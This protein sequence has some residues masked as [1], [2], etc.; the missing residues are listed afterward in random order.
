MDALIQDVRY[1]LRMCLRSPGFTI[2]A[3][4]ALALGI[5]ANTAIFTVVNAV[6]IERLPFR[7]PSRLV[8]LWETNARRPGRPNTLGPA[9]VIRWIERAT[10]F[11][12]IAPFYDYQ[13]NLT[14]GGEPE[15]IIAQDVTADYFPTLGVSPIAGRI[16]A[17]DEGPTG[18]DAVAVLSFGLWQ[19]RFVGSGE[20]VGRSIQIN[21]HPITVIGVMPADARLFIRR[22]SLVG[23]PAEIWM[24]FAFTAANR[25]PRG[26][27]MS[28]IARLKPGVQ[29]SEAQAQ[30]ET[31]MTG[32][33]KEFPEFDTGWSAMVVPMHRELSGDL[34]PALLVLSGAVGFVLLIACANVAN[35]L[36]ARGAA[37]RREMAIR[38]ALG[39]ARFRVIRQLLTESLVLCVLGGAA[40]LL[41]A[42]WGLALLVAISPEGLAD[43]SAVHLSYPVLAFTALVSIVTTIVC[44]FAPA[45]EASR[46]EVQ[47]GLKDGSRH[48]GAGV[49]HRRIRQGF[50]VSEIAL[51]VV[52]L[53]GAG[54]MIKSFGTL[55]S[56]NPGFDAQ[57]VLTARL[58]IPAARYPDDP[59]RLNFFSN[60]VAR[61]AALPGVESAGAISFLPL[62]GLGAATDFAIVG[63]PAAAAGQ[64]LATDVRVCDNGYFQAMRVPLVSGR[65][66]SERERHAKANVVIVNETLARHFFPSGDALGKS[67]VISMNLPNVPTEIIGIV[68][69]VKS[70][71]FASETHPMTYWPHPQLVYTA[72]TLTIRTLGD[73]AALAPLVEREVRS[74]DK[75]QPVAE[76][77]TMEQW[78]SRSLSQARFSS[79]LLATFA[80]LA[81][82]LA[83]IGIYGVMSYAVS[84]R[85]PEI[86]IRLALG[87]NARDILRMIVGS[88][89]RLAALGL[90]IGVVL[91]LALGRTV[92]SLLY[93]TASTDPLTFAAVAGVLAGV[94]LV[95]GYVPARRAARIPPVEA[96][97]YQ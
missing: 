82:L 18:H 8:A 89:A 55:R 23:K 37:R 95:A 79:T 15:E 84:Q 24:P 34:R 74:L 9:N 5:G 80:G 62:A 97:R 27:Y 29:M 2:V 67:L 64:A 39:A 6:L 47:E 93:E 56:V 66:F 42:Q 72:M 68:G 75:D 41:V 20:V 60:V 77:R 25:T 35:L 88:T 78:V 21:G 76:V 14:G 86:G 10:V 11:E 3:V 26:R 19:R 63:Q 57:H 87:A 31:I 50:V 96:L 81:L 12:R 71:G 32:L 91:A 43:F 1:A 90:A 54:L 58:T 59:S 28:A 13:V 40:G 4:L 45:F 16:F 83:A 46:A 7:D 69:D 65:L 33:T 36:L 48:I 73:P 30:L 70:G 53:V 44:G 94:A 85:T 61:V 92:A 38:S 51:A 52:L 17:P 49:R 22:G